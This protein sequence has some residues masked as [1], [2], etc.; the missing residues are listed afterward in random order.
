MGLNKVPEEHFEI[1][2]FTFKIIPPKLCQLGSHSL[3]QG[4]CCYDTAIYWHKNNKMSKPGPRS[5]APMRLSAGRRSRVGPSPDFVGNKN[6]VLMACSDMEE[7]GKWTEIFIK[8]NGSEHLL[9]PHSLIFPRSICGLS[10]HG[11]G[12]SLK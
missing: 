2:E 10:F 8:K 4:I 6:R 12:S 3:A 9:S 11:T 1:P 5:A 7:S